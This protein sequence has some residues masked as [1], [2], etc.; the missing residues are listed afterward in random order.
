MR[1]VLRDESRV[2]TRPKEIIQGCRK[3]YSYIIT[4]VFAGMKHGVDYLNDIV[5]RKCN[6]YNNN[7]QYI[8]Q[9]WGEGVRG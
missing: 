5:P 9:L 2:G 6:I 3:N 4:D 1:S 7:F 8:I